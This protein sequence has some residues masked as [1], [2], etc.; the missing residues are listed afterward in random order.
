MELVL[1]N[2]II[3]NLVSPSIEFKNKVIFENSYFCKCSFNYTYFLGG[4][5]ID[6]CVFESYL[7]FEAG[8]HNQNNN[9]F[10]I[11]NSHFKS[12]VNFFDCLFQSGVEII[13]NHFEKRNQYTRE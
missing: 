4:L 8:G 3:D 5:T 2:C 7:D 10:T 11:K 12:F 9:L 6:N 13:N 1:I